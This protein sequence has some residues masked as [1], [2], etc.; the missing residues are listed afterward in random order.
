MEHQLANAVLMIRPVRFESN[1]ETA[2]SNR[3]QGNTV[4]GPAEQQQAAAREFDALAEKLADR[5]IEVIVFDDTPEPHTPDS[6]FPN[7]WVSFHADGRVVLYPMEA[8][9]RRRERRPDIIEALDDD[10]GFSVREV[11][12]LSPHEANAHFLEGTG[13]MVLDRVNRVP[14]VADPARPA[15]RLRAAARLRRRRVRRGRPQRCRDL[16]H[17]RADERR[18]RAGRDL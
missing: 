4:L 7:N 12:D 17:E 10:F 18:R 14:V 3:F 5:G 16:S 6:I 13:S 11:V 1:P 9:N 8:P 15:R 2:A